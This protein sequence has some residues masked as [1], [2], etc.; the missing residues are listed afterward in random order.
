MFATR[1]EWA[2]HELPAHFPQLCERQGTTTQA[3][4]QSPPMPPKR[5]NDRLEMWP[6]LSEAR[7]AATSADTPCPLCR[8]VLRGAKKYIS[9]LGKH[10]ESIALAAI[11]QELR[12]D[13]AEEDS[14]TST[15]NSQAP[16][17]NSNFESQQDVGAHEGGVATVVSP[18]ARAPPGP[19]PGGRSIDFSQRRET[20]QLADVD[21]FN[22]ETE[23]KVAPAS[24]ER[25]KL[26]EA[27]AAARGK[28]EAEVEAGA[29]PFSLAKHTKNFAGDRA[30]QGSGHHETSSPTLKR[31]VASTKASG[32]SSP[33]VP[34]K[35]N[36]AAKSSDRDVFIGGSSGVEPAAQWICVCRLTPLQ[37]LRF[38]LTLSSI[39]VGRK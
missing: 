2:Q 37:L 38:V 24:A 23:V 30:P 6:S 18:S 20:M 13:S 17:V 9:H 34:R 1:T 3:T 35:S 39:D 11:A 27:K 21:E 7:D 8:A 33:R 29:A 26:R 16:D 28:D 10:L 31:R 4:T 32:G 36:K 14:F 12:E 19:M 22:E 15:Q 5:P 25:Q